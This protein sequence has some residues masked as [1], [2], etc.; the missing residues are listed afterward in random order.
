MDAPA[1]ILDSWALIA[2]LEDEPSAVKIEQVLSDAIASYTRLLM[3]CINLG[4]VWYSIA[5][6]YT[7]NTADAAIQRVLSMGIESIDVDW[8]ISYQAA[9]FKAKHSIAYADCFAAAL[10][11][12]EKTSLITGDPEFKQLEDQIFIQWV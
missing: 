12:I 8:E 6:A 1:I 7:E 3:T 11:Y 5:R 2:F 10:A 9:K 4:E